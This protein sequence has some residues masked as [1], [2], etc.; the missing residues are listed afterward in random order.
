MEKGN[1]MT[2]RE[3][4]DLIN[5]LDVVMN[6]ISILAR[7]DKRMHKRIFDAYFPLLDILEEEEYFLGMSEQME[8]EMA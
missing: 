2:H 8:R 5:E 3:L 4:N 6:K 7:S 1:G